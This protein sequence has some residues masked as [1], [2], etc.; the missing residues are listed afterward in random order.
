VWVKMAIKK[1]KSCAL[2][3]TFM[4]GSKVSQMGRWSVAS[5]ASICIAVG[6]QCRP[7]G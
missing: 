3:I 1:T 4:Y 2:Q 5:N 7:E 6:R